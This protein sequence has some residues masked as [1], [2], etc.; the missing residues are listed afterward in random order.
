MSFF[1]GGRTVA[2]VAILS[3]A[4]ALPAAAQSAAGAM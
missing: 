2:I 4:I 3:G 1:N